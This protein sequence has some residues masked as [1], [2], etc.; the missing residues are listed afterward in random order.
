MSSTAS[1]QTS[2]V[3]CIRNVL[4]ETNRELRHFLPGWSWSIQCLLSQSLEG[5]S[6][7]P[8]QVR[9]YS[10]FLQ[11]LGPQDVHLLH[12]LDTQTHTISIWSGNKPMPHFK[13]QR[14]SYRELV[15]TLNVEQTTEG[16]KRE[17]RPVGKQLTPWAKARRRKGRGGVT[18]TRSLDQELEELV[19]RPRR[20]RGT[21]GHCWYLWVGLNTPVLRALKVITGQNQLLQ[22]GPHTASHRRNRWRGERGLFSAPLFSVSLQWA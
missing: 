9:D 1:L 7:L 2:H 6:S 3:P 8:D 10:V 19:L 13:I 11:P 22:L 4:A 17:L 15:T 18:R 20:S 12:S 14:M 16:R 21:I 5:A